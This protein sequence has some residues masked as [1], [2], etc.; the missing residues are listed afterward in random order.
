[1]TTDKTITC[2]SCA[3]Q[4]HWLDV[5]PGNICLACHAVKTENATPQELYNSVMNYFGGQK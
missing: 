5:F 4:I 2:T 1:M 3:S